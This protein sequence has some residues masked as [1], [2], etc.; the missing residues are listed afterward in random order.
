MFKTLNQMDVANYDNFLEGLSE[1]NLNQRLNK[2]YKIRDKISKKYSFTYNDPD[3]AAQQ[4]ARNDLDKE[5]DK[6]VEVIEKL[7]AFAKENKCALA[8]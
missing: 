1:A 5:Y 2:L 8:K 6:V 4:K 3:L 7:Y